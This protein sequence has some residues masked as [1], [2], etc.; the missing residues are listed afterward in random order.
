MSR[1]AFLADHDFNEHI[2]LGLMRRE[3][4]IDL[5]RCRD[6]GLA[7]ELDVK[8][9]EYAAAVQKVVVSH[10]VNTM[11]A[12]ASLRIKRG[13][14]MS[15]LVLVP[16]SSPVRAVVEDL[17]LIWSATTADEWHGRIQFLPL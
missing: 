15:G 16:Q 9:L 2:V 14:V 17:L 10:D 4:A 3:P 1:P 12:E 6:V 7:N 5:I 13:V 11:S 8:V